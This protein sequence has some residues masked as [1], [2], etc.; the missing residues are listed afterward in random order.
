MNNGWHEAV[1]MVS[2]LNRIAED[3][4]IVGNWQV[5]DEGKVDPR[6]LNV[7][8][9]SQ[10]V[11]G[12]YKLMKNPSTNKGFIRFV[13]LDNQPQKQIR[14]A[15]QIWES[16]GIFDLNFR[17]T[18]IN[19][20]F[21]QLLN[22]GWTAFNEPT[23]YEFGPVVVSE[24][25]MIGPDGV[26]FALIERISP[27]L[28]EVGD[29][30]EI[31]RSFN[32]SLI[33]KDLEKSYK[34]FNETLGFK[35]AMELIGHNLPPGPNVLGLAHNIAPNHAMDV[36]IIH[37]NGVTDGSVELLYLHDI[38]GRDFSK[39]ARPYN[40]GITALRFPIDDVLKKA[41]DLKQN[42]I[43]LVYQPTT[44]EL[45]PYGDVK[46]FALELPEGGWIEFFEPLN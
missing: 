18:D 27:P 43:P 7:W 8:G 32:S 1:I 25:L 20:K 23:Q 21:E 40:L 13:S 41:D 29:P 34:F 35:K 6:Q 19:K 37:P 42:D 30:N 33:V 15:G 31:S 5:L 39:D 46:I 4:E 24:V 28:E 9:V 2:D 10:Y 17:V 26:C 38:E 36:Y 14:P 44:F 3:L 16:G 22:R 12:C 45:A 11:T